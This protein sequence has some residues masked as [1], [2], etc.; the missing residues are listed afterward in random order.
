MA[1][2]REEKTSLALPRFASGCTPADLRSTRCI[3]PIFLYFLLCSES[4][5]LTSYGSDRGSFDQW[6]AEISKSS[7]K[8]RAYTPFSLCANLGVGSLPRTT[9]CYGNC[10][11]WP[12]RMLLALPGARVRCAC[13]DEG[14]TSGGRRGRTAASGDGSRGEWCDSDI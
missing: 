10:S 4:V 8:A 11:C 2:V 5:R 12:L 1:I 3:L 7:R 14:E 9:G 6:S 13:S